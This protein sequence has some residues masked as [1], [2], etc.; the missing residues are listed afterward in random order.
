[1]SIEMEWLTVEPVCSLPEGCNDWGATNDGHVFATCPTA[2]G[3]LVFVWDGVAGASF[4]RIAQLRDESQ[5]AFASPDGNHFAYVGIRGDRLFVGRDGIEDPPIEDFTRSVPVTFDRRGTHVAYGAKLGGTFRLVLDGEPIGTGEL[6]PIEAV[7]S[8]DGR[9]LA[10]VE[11]RDAG[12]DA[13]FRIV[14]DGQ[15]GE[16]FS[17]MRNADGAMQFS[18]DGQRFACYTIDG[19]GGASWIVDGQRQRS[20]NDTRPMSMARVRGVGVVEPPLIAGFSPD[21]RRFA[22]FADVVEK[23]VAIVEDDVPGP[24]FKAL[25]PFNFSPDSRHLAYAALTDHG[26]VAQVLDGAPI[27]EWPGRNALRNIF[28]ANSAHVAMIFEREEGGLFRKHSVFD[29]ALD[30]QCLGEQLATDAGMDPTFSPDGN[31]VAW[32]ARRRDDTVVAVVD[33]TA[34]ERP[35]SVNTQVQFDP[36]GRL[37]RGV[38]IDSK[39]AMVVGDRPGP[40]ADAGIP[41]FTI[42][43]LYGRTSAGAQLATYRI[44]RTGQVAWAGR[45]GDRVCPVLDD[46]VG[47]PFDSIHGCLVDDDAVSWWGQRDEQIFRIRRELAPPKAD[48][49]RSSGTP[50]TTSTARAS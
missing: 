47:P 40:Q 34:E 45:F 36:A 15:S 12:R 29:V 44:A 43:E 50:A 33:G 14:V 2:D 32:W 46:E 49:N 25:L 5:A 28:S 38:Q 4:D 11:I 30:G 8:D 31:H 37:V 20:I 42:D 10:Y 39:V 21:G 3:R 7:F 48:G 41:V 16:W 26:T 17:G 23:G 22:Y 35:W 1:M 9:R 24:L 19:R 6:A 27:G 13:Q 18:P